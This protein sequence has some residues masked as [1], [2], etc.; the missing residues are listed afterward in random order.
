MTDD[1]PQSDRPR[2]RLLVVTGMSGAGKST[3][4]QVLEDLGWEAHDNFPIRLLGALVDGTGTVPAP[5]AIGVDSRA[6]DFA[7]DD[8]AADIHALAGSA[9]LS[10]QI[11]FLDCADAEI[12]RRY[13]ETRRP[14]PLSQSVGPVETGIRA[15]R[16]LLEPLRD[17]ADIIVDTSS[18]TSNQLQQVVREHFAQSAT[19]EMSVTVSSFG[20]SRGMPPLADLLFDVRY[21]DNPHWVAQ[22]R[23]L[24]GLD[25]EVGDHIRADPAFAPSFARIA[26]AV[27][28]LVPRY[29][30]HGRSYLNIAFGCTGGK[31]RSV[32]CA[33]QVA[34]ILREAGFSPTVIHRNLQIQT[35][36]KPGA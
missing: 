4:L 26:D 27:L 17:I 7:P 19:R 20:F 16:A 2:Q 35:L 33:E 13:N 25:P 3:V 22:L 34:A 24:T 30:A 23:P 5:L 18:F 10:S 11:L 9:G 1:S 36:D 15:E 14:H 28:D 12:G 21:L 8:I 31:H 32:F 6:R 29:A